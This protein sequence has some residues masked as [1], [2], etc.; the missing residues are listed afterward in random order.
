MY[1]NGAQIQMRRPRETSLVVKNHSINVT[2]VLGMA[3]AWLVFFVGWVSFFTF[4][5]PPK[6]PPYCTSDDGG[7]RIFS[8]LSWCGHSLSVGSSGVFALPGWLA[9]GKRG[10]VTRRSATGGTS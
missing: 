5:L 4:T 3:A 1:D 9:S 2:R 7:C 6:R 10:A 8:D